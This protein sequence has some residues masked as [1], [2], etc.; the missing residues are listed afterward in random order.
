MKRCVRWVAALV[1]GTAPHV[2][3]SNPPAQSGTGEGNL[4][5]G[6]SEPREPQPFTREH[7]LL[8]AV[9]QGD[10]ATVERALELGVAVETADDLQRSALLLAARDAQDADLV[11]FLHEQGGAID[12]ADASGRT[13]LSYAASSGQLDLVDYLASN[14]AQFDLADRRGRTPLFHAVMSQQLDVVRW[15]LDR[16]AAVDAH[17]RYADTPLIMAC[18]KGYDAIARLLIERGADL[19]ARNRQGRSASDRA[20]PELAV[21]RAGPTS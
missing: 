12:R 17:D 2:A 10:R 9:R 18:S 21:C 8:D 14:G 19:E 7:R 20:A 11:R 6:T 16:G 5:M 13:P 3:L 1:I 4:L 15:L